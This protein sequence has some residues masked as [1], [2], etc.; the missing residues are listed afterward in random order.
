VENPDLTIEISGIYRMSY[1]NTKNII[2]IVFWNVILIILIFLI[3][4][5]AFGQYRKPPNFLSQLAKDWSVGVNVGRTAFFG[6]ISL[7]DEEFNEKMSKEGAWG[8]GFSIAREFTPV[9]GLRFYGLFGQLSGSNSKSTF[10]SNIREYSINLSADLLN[11]LIP[12]N[13]ARFHPYFIAGMGQ[14]TFDTRLKY[15]DPNKADETA[16]STAPEFVYLFGGGAF[17][18]ISQSFDLKAEFMGRRMDND[19]IDG[20]TNKKDNDY[21]SYLSIGARYKIN[22]IPRDVRYYKRLGMK[23]P[24]IRR[25]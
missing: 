2:F 15:F 16:S 11:M 9:F 22:N 18:V 4:G 5:N 10:V 17:Y 8:Y 1:R 23:S 6:D 14:F 3:Q 24:L 12:E 21:Y 13:D 25:R 20:T 7:Y 19:R